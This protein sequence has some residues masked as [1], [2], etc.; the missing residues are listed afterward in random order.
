M[1]TG[2]DWIF[3]ADSDLE[4]SYV[5]SSSLDEG[6]LVSDY[7][8]L[9]TK[10]GYSLDATYTSDVGNKRYS[11]SDFQITVSSSSDNSFINLSITPLS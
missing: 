3:Y 1:Y 2:E 8:G 9:L 5:A 6:I 7:E 4:G 11:N 10:K